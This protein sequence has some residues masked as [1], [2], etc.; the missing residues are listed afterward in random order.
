VRLKFFIFIAFFHKIV[1]HETKDLRYQQRS[2]AIQTNAVFP[3]PFAPT[4]AIVGAIL[5]T[6]I[7][8]K[9]KEE[10]RKKCATKLEINHHPT[11]N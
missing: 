5:V 7:S 10:K 9:L 4:I 8:I 3:H 1:G 6:S 2:H 11:Q